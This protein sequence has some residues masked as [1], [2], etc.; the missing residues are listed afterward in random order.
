MKN[1]IILAILLSSRFCFGQNSETEKLVNSVVNDIIPKENQYFNLIDSS[2]IYNRYYHLGDDELEYFKKEYP[3]F[4]FNDIIATNRG[5]KEVLSWKNFKIEK[6]RLYDFANIP[7]YYSYT[8]H[9]YLIPYNIPKNKFD[10][11]VKNK[12]KNQ[13]IIRYKKNWSKKRIEKVTDKA[14][15]K[16]NNNITRENKTYYRFS[17][18][19]FSDN[20]YAIISVD[21]PDSGVSYI[22]QKSNNKWEQIFTFNRWVH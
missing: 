17:T 1:I 22:Y 12:M 21:N 5:K 18:P 13:L 16:H 15:K 14:W 11:L 20:G 9:S 2:F 4:D 7:E 8:Q 19:Y 10:S 3:N 6:A